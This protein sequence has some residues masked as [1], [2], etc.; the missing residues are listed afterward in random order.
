MT[1]RSQNNIFKPKKIFAASKHPLPED[2]KLRNALIVIKNPKWTHA[3]EDELSALERNETRKLVDQPLE[4]SVI[5]CK[6]VF[7]VKRNPNGSVLRYKAR[8]VV[9]GFN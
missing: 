1:T 4:R 7:R 6:W 5:G 8:L 2:A 3:M 9:K